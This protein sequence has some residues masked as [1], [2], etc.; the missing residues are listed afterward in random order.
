M[1]NDMLMMAQVGLRIN[2]HRHSGTQARTHTKNVHTHI[3]TH[4]VAPDDM[5][6]MAQ[7]GLQMPGVYLVSD[8]CV[9]V[10]A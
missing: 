6:M 5:L 1:L 4:R 8:L 7:V 3:C 2:T 10:Y 9:C